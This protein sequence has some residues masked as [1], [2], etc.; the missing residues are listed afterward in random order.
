MRLSNGDERDGGVGFGSLG[1]TLDAIDYPITNEELLAAHGDDRLE[2]TDETVTLREVL[3]PV[4]GETYESAEAVRETIM[5]MVG[6][7]AIGR[8]GYS[9][10]GG[11][12][13][14]EDPA[15]GDENES[16]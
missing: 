15:P 7:E 2:L 10:R 8:K 13:P 4:D 12:S 16:F 9:D 3:G 5:T 1:E 6:D 11:E 14:G